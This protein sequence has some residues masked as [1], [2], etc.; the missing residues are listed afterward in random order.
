TPGPDAA[1]TYSNI[2]LG[3]TDGINMV[4]RSFELLVAPV[5]QA[6]VVTPVPDR[7]VREGDP[8]HIQLR[9][10]DPEGDTL[11]Y[12]SP[13]LPPGPFLDP[14]T[15]VFEWSPGFTQAGVYTVPFFVSD[16]FSAT[17]I[18]STFT[19]LNANGA[20]I[21]DE[22]GPYQLL[23]NQPLSFRAFAFD[24]DNP[25]FVPQDR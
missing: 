3:V 18:Q 1:G 5:N 13:L 9:A 24:P 22:L 10:T 21:F 6:P 19:V 14:N 12:F 25:G 7:I 20:P 16:G 8:I 23:E 15:G 11:G 4:T 17:R 2:T